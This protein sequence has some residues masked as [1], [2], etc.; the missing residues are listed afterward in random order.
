MAKDPYGGR[1]PFVRG[2]DT[3][4]AASDSVADSAGTKRGEVLEALRLAGARGLT[5]WEIQQR[6]G[7]LHQ[8]MTARRRELV[9]RGLVRDSGRRRATQTGRQAVVWVLVTLEP[10]Q[11]F[12]EF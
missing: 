12:L 9:L 3:S 7:G 10:S 11:G 4:E 2:S 1:P 5:D 8:S 6:T